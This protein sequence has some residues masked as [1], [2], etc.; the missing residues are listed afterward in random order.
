MKRKIEVY[1][2]Y[3]S[4]CGLCHSV[5]AVQYD[6]KNGFFKPKLQD[7]NFTFCENFC[8]A[9]GNWIKE[10]DPKKNW[11]RYIN[12]RV[13]WSTDPKLRFSASSGGTITAITEYLL[14]KKLVDAI[15]HTH[16]S[17]Q[18]QIKTEYAVSD[19]VEELRD[20]I[21]SRYTV[22]SPLI[23]LLQ[24]VS[25][26]KKYAVIGKP[27]DILALRRYLNA[28]SEL[29]SNIVYLIS[30]FCAGV[31][32]ENANR[33]L[34]DE[35]KTNE[36]E[37]KY[38]TYRG[39]GWPG[40]ATAT[41]SKGKKHSMSYNDSWGKILGRDINKF[42]RFCMDGI[43]EFADISCGDAWYL[44][45]DGTPDFNEHD[46]RNITFTR[47]Q[48]GDELLKMCVKDGV[49]V[50]ETYDVAN[51]K[52]IQ[53]YQYERRSQTYSRVLGM[54][55]CGRKTPYYSLKILRK[56]TYELKETQIIKEI[57]GTIKRVISGK[58]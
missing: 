39:E 57:A 56:F 15:I 28:H 33:K 54:K 51:L 22:S 25:Y 32:S 36:Q 43:G 47:T 42:C 30:F 12:A 41:S 52:K 11:G 16:V 31:P 27:C 44:D 19:C 49:V 6:Y 55:L 10:I 46:G 29:Y 13:T 50:S 7:N 40:F 20:N 8:P 38:L 2:E 14:K 34:L 48:K 18:S 53:K 21:G 58:M 24:C 26:D 35:L 45:E 17:K 1:K 3:C 4:G 9:S 23:E 37:C 5:E